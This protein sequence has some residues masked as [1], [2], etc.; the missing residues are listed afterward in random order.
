MLS[1][2]HTRELLPVRRHER[3]EVRYGTSFRPRNDRTR[4]CI[5]CATNALRRRTARN[6]FG[7][8]STGSWIVRG[9]NL[10]LPGNVV[11][12]ALLCLAL[13]CSVVREAWFTSKVRF[14]TKELTFFFMLAPYRL[15]LQI[16]RRCDSPPANP[17]LI[18]TPIVMA[19]LC[20]RTIVCSKLDGSPASRARAS[21]IR[22][23][24]CR[25]ADRHANHA[26]D[27]CGA[28]DLESC[29]EVLTAVPLS[30]WR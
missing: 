21:P 26:R 23:A 19:Y 12:M 16:K 2:S 14:L 5:H 30:G 24:R 8:R 9:L 27:I 25:T 10:T 11:G 17:V 20:S 18:A 6:T 15:A 7:L 13:T 22:S 29:S 4:P 1:V 28:D 3:F